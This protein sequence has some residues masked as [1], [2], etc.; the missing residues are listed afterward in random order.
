MMPACSAMRFLLLVAI[1]SVLCLLVQCND[2][3]ESSR[4][5]NG[6]VLNKHEMPWLTPV[7]YSNYK[8]V[9]NP[10]CTGSIIGKYHVLTAAHC[11]NAGWVGTGVHKRS[12][13]VSFNKIVKWNTA[14]GVDI[15]VITLEDEIEFK[16]G[17]VE[18]AKLASPCESCCPTCSKN[19]DIDLTAAGWGRDPSDPEGSTQDSPKK[20]TM[21]C[22]KESKMD[23]FHY[24]RA[25]D[26]SDPHH[27]D[28]C[29][30]DSG[31]PLI[32]KNVIYGTVVRGGYCTKDPI[33]RYGRWGTY[34]NVRHPEIQDFIKSI[35]SDVEIEGQ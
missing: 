22:D 9:V 4:V 23:D 20:T 32:N 15:A 7:F 26:K 27:K 6:T 34:A 33:S 2:G 5:L 17:V 16:P 29:K 8:N 28:V 30:G 19:C 35:V 14:P 21:V 13:V 18:K 3:G 25:I 10:A 24:F 31:G 1:G 12:E 11:Y